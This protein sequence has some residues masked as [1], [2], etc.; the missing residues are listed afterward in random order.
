MTRRN[1][2]FHTMNLGDNT[3]NGGVQKVFINSIDGL[4][5]AVAFQ[6]TGNVGLKRVLMTRG[7]EVIEKE[8][9][10][11]T[12]NNDFG[13]TS[14][15]GLLKML[16]KIFLDNFNI[17]TTHREKYNLVLGH[18]ITSAALIMS[19]RA[20]RRIIFLHSDRMFQE[21]KAK[22]LL[23]VIFLFLAH[24]EFV[25]PTTSIIAKAKKLGARNCAVIPTPVFNS[26]Q[27]NNC[28]SYKNGSKMNLCYIG[29]ISPIKNLLTTIDFIHFLCM[30]GVECEYHIYGKPF[31]N[32]QEDYLNLIKQRIVE[33][34]LSDFIQFKGLTL[35]PYETFSKYHFSL[36]FSNGEAI[37][38][39][40]LESLEAG[41]PVIGNVADGVNDLVGDHRGILFKDYNFT[42]EI[43]GSIEN[44]DWQKFLTSRDSFLEGFRIKNFENNL[45]GDK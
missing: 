27:K 25:A 44:F 18:D 13:G 36:I 42:R 1:L 30:N 24:V 28:S 37:P 9:C 23:R 4:E 19:F 32:E 41:V 12:L 33:L 6:H 34:Q 45:I 26:I 21:R 29:R 3:I 22:F 15:L 40:G 5:N 10:I 11:P 20:K 39:A 35:N 38:L 31:T 16:C 7:I 2:V 17:W 8:F 43:L 14:W